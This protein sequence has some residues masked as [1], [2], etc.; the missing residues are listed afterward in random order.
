[1][2]SQKMPLNALIFAHICSYLSFN[3]PQSKEACKMISQNM[4]LN[5]C[6]Y[7]HMLILIF[8]PF[9]KQRGLQ[10]DIT[11]DATQCS[12]LHTYA[13]SFVSIVHKAKRLAK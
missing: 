11:D 9:T 4:P 5:A 8:H 2:V 13:H 6:I 10:N 1:M 12:Y 3:R 7:T